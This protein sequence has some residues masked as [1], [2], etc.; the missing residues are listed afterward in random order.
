MCDRTRSSHSDYEI[1]IASSKSHCHRPGKWNQK[2][3]N[4]VKK[5]VLKEESHCIKE[6]CLPFEVQK[7]TTIHERFFLQP[8]FNHTVSIIAA[9]AISKQ[10]PPA[11]LPN[12]IRVHL[13][14]SGRLT[15]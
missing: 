13:I 7:M 1:Q 15:S 2:K 11:V 4:C 12:P 14:Q 10:I 8:T 6:R 3:E 5:L 9:K